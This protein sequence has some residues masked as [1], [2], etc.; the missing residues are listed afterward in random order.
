MAVTIEPRGPEI[1]EEFLAKMAETFEAEAVARKDRCWHW[2]FNPPLGPGAPEVVVL[3]AWKDGQLA[4]G[5]ILGVAAYML[6][7]QLRYFRT[8]Y[9][10]NI[11]PRRRGLGINLIKS[12]Y[13]AP[14][15]GIPIADQLARINRK[16]GGHDAERIH[17][18]APLRAGSA[19]ARR[20]RILVP[21]AGIGN[22]LWHAW[23]GLSGFRGPGL[24]QGE[25]ITDAAEFGEEHDAFW[26]RSAAHHDFIQV[27]SAAFMTWRFREMPLQKYDVLQLRRNGELRGYVVVG[28]DIDPVRGTGQV[29][30]ILTI[31]DDPRELALLFRAAQRRLGALGADVAAFGCVMRPALIEGARMAGFSRMK[32]TRPAQVVY[33]DPDETRRIDDDLRKLYLTRADQDEDY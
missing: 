4:G 17:M 32:T 24:R 27:R 7:G 11:D 5:S 12:F 6:H 21:L 26:E 33:T 2:L 14:A 31:D 30:D 1:R 18:F 22:L 3:S 25:T 15:I 20:K 9:G 16:L 13:D 28:H 8:P 19:L 29:T 23:R 10:T